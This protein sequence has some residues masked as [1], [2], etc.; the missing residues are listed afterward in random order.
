[1]SSSSCSSADICCCR[2]RLEINARWSIHRLLNRWVETE[3]YAHRRRITWMLYCITRLA[4]AIAFAKY[5]KVSLVQCCSMI[6]IANVS[7]VDRSESQRRKV[8]HFF[9]LVSS[10]EFHQERCE[11][12]LTKRK[13]RKSRR[14]NA[15]NQHFA[16]GNFVLCIRFWENSTKR[17]FCVIDKKTERDG[18]R[19]GVGVEQ[20]EKRLRAEF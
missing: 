4:N 3:I 2:D 15:T 12:H 7:A 6:R 19:A 9:F 8:I 5:L 11:A 18:I 20:E 16:Q 14:R 1:M 10:Y 13:N 17:D